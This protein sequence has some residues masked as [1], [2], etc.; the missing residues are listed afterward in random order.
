MSSNT[1]STTGRPEA[2]GA[3]LSRLASFP[4]AAAARTRR[5]PLDAYAG[6][7]R[8]LA[9]VYEALERAADGPAASVL[10]Q[11][12]P[13]EL[14]RLRLLSDDLGA[15]AGR[16]LAS[17]PEAELRAEVLAERIRLW[18]QHSPSSLPG[19][20][21][22]F[23]GSAVALA[24]PPKQIAACFALKEGTGTAFIRRAE[25]IR[26]AETPA[27]DA[28][29]HAAAALLAIVAALHPADTRSLNQLARVI[30]PQAGNYAIPD[31]LIEIRAALRA[32]ART[33][34]EIPYYGLRF[35]ERGRE[36]TWSDSCWLATLAKLEQKAIDAQIAWVGRLLS[37]RGM[38]QLLLEEHLYAL[39][40]ELSA[41]RPS[42]RGRYA[43]LSVAA[44]K[45][46]E[47]RRA[48]I[49]DD[50]MAAI[51]GAFDALDLGGP[52]DARLGSVLVAAVADE[53][54]GIPQAV[55]SVTGWFAEPQ[56]FPPALVDAVHAT[57]AAARA[58]VR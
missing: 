13:S 11:L 10:S 15:F 40:E 2:A 31:D 3:D 45:L 51:A 46:A 49:A 54:A 39:A 30:N 48:Y 34:E 20:V 26:T 23:G 58:A 12:P 37:S 25:Q 56:R 38:P 8:C 21:A 35:A 42:E 9:T 57:V 6:L 53:A 27:D 33:W 52:P 16:E 17:M 47:Q 4:F 55:E 36:W 22:V 24:A 14:R 19:V 32:G 7:L 41:A 18:A 44:G 43:R 50:D 28:A 29:T 5:L 1:Q